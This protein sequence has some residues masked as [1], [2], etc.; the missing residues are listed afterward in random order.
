FVFEPERLDAQI[1]DRFFHLEVEDRTYLLDTA[2]LGQ[3]KDE[4]T[5]RGA[6]VRRTLDRLGRATTQQDKDIATL[7]LRLGLAE[8]QNPRHAA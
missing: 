7:A 3:F 6:F 2:L 1:R 5:I 4:A 8:F